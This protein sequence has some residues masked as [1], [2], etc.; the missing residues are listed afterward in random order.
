MFPGGKNKKS[1]IEQSAVKQHWDELKGPI[2]QTTISP[3]KIQFI[4]FM[5]RL[6]SFEP[7]S[8][9]VSYTVSSG[10]FPAE[11][12]HR[13]MHSSDAE[14]CSQFKNAKVLLEILSPG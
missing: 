3:V 1:C 12:Q 2:G 13:N 8:L 14:G 11:I 4:F 10:N 6:I 9:I 7:H 5:T